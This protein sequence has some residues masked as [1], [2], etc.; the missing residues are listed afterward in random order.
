MSLHDESEGGRR[1]TYNELQDFSGRMDVRFQSVMD[2][3][4]EARIEAREAHNRL[5]EDWTD[6]LKTSIEHA[7]RM[8]RVEA[9]VKSINAQR[10]ADAA[11]ASTERR[12]FWAQVIGVS[13]L[14][15]GLFMWGVSLLKGARP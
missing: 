3:I 2:A 15:T 12:Y 8:D 6:L 9:D 1:V 14:V 7:G 13:S 10:V 11:E 4:K 5:R